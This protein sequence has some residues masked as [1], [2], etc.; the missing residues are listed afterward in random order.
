MSYIVGG[1]VVFRETAVNSDTYR[2][3]ERE[4]FADTPCFASGGLEVVLFIGGVSN[5]PRAIIGNM[6]HFSTR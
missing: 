3:I 2:M 6:V 1:S 5:Q 4:S